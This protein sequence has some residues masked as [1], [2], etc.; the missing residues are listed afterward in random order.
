MTFSPGPTQQVAAIDAFDLPVNAFDL[1][2]NT[3]APENS[4]VIP[5]FCG[6]VFGYVKLHSLSRRC[7][8]STDPLHKIV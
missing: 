7:E 6:L 5:V 2:V 4:A 8:S 1:P 3:N